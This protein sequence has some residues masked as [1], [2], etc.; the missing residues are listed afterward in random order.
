M[1]NQEQSTPLTI[2]LNNK[3][4]T[5]DG[6]MKIKNNTIYCNGKKMTP[7]SQFD[8]ENPNQVA[9]K[10]PNFGFEVRDNRGEVFAKV[11]IGNS[12]ITFK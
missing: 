8:I 7:F 10:S 2:C 4:V 6:K 5:C 3:C 11:R 9:F 1:S 12:S